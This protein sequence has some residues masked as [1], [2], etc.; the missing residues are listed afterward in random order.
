MSETIQIVRTLPIF[1]LPIVIFPGHFV[2]LHIFEFKYRAM[3]S[4]VLR[5]DKCFGI[6]RIDPKTGRIATTGCMIEILEVDPLEDGRMNIEGVGRNRYELLK[7]VSDAPYIIAE[8][9]L[10]Q[11]IEPEPQA[12]PVADEVKHALQEVFRL[13][14]KLNPK[15]RLFHLQELPEDPET[16][17]FFIPA[18][19]YASSEDQQRILEM[20]SILERLQSELE[21]CSTAVK[22]MA[23][24][25]SLKDAF[26]K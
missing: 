11:E 8:V 3:I 21:F 23:A 1:P 25:A 20:D 16:L 13:S 9:K 22:Y 17:S 26:D 2:P 15:N 14:G 18:T 12:I 19:L 6:L 24:V 4:D 10:L 5:S 7:V